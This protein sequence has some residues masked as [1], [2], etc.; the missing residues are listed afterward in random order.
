MSARYPPAT[1]TTTPAT[2]VR[3]MK[4]DRRVTIHPGDALP[5]R[6]SRE[7]GV[8]RL[9]LRCLGAG[10]QFVSPGT[11][12]ARLNPDCDTAPKRPRDDSD[13][14]NSVVMLLEFGGF[15][16][17]MAGDLTWNVEA[18]VVCPVNLA[19]PVDV[20]QVTHHGLDQSNNPLV[21]HALSPTVAIMSNGTGKGCEP[22]TFTTLTTEPSIKALFQIHR[23]LRSDSEHNTA[24]E[25]IANLERQCAGNFIKLSVAPDSATYV[26]SIPATGRA[27]KFQTRSHPAAAAQ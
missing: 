21:V 6:Q 16:L 19:G 27:Q 22:G 5:L 2:P 13:N 11:G 24:P 26:V 10:Q 17:F 8:A 18:N 15:H 14:A 7:T 9:T 1:R 25:N 20:Y 23:N 4:V 12:R 3:E